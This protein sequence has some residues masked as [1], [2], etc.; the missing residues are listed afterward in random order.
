MWSLNTTN[1]DNGNHAVGSFLRVIGPS[2]IEKYT[3]GDISVL[4]SKNSLLILKSPLV[5]LPTLV[6]EMIESKVSC[7]FVLVGCQVESM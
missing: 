6:N 5:M 7:G 4:V 3:S 1:R 2:P